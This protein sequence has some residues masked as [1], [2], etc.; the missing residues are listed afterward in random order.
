MT[1]PMCDQPGCGHPR[2]QHNVS[3]TTWYDDGLVDGACLFDDTGTNTFDDCL[4]FVPKSRKTPEPKQIPI[5]KGE[6]VT[7]HECPEAVTVPTENE[8]YQGLVSA[9]LLLR[10]QEFHFPADSIASAIDEL[11]RLRSLAAEVDMWS[12]SVDDEDLM[13][14]ISEAESFDGE[15]RT[16]MLDLI[17]RLVAAVKAGLRLPVPVEREQEIREAVLDE[18]FAN[19]GSQGWDVG[20]TDHPTKG[21]NLDI[22]DPNSPAAVPVEELPT[23]DP[24]HSASTTD[25]PHNAWRAGY[26]FGWNDKHNGGPW[27]KSE[28]N[29]YPEVVAE[30]EWETRRVRSD[31]TPVAAWEDSPIIDLGWYIERRTKAVPAGE[32]PPVTHPVD[33]SVE[34][35]AGWEYGLVNPD[36]EFGEYGRDDRAH[37]VSTD[38]EHIE[39]QWR[40]GDPLIQFVKRVSAGEWQPVEPE[41]PAQF[42][43]EPHSRAC[44]FRWHD[45][46]AE[47]HSNC[48]TCGGKPKEI[49]ARSEAS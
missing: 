31:G 38:R 36:A 17:P 37:L 20:M 8:R 9:M 35:E 5:D 32:W 24:L 23:T 21:V 14:L 22:C 18:V 26:R 4:E 29:P 12:E 42:E 13:C 6:K 1:Q 40:R 25:S 28:T 15:D 45:H 34:G 7:A 47:C 33:T 30:P 2:N 10:Q 41:P 43:S 49:T 16:Q 19:L 46:G 3:G 27:R 48:P 39:R 44:G 11:K